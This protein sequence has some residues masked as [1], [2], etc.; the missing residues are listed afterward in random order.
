MEERNEINNRLLKEKIVNRCING[1]S[2]TKHITRED[3]PYISCDFGYIFTT[4]DETIEAIVKITVRDSEYYISVSEG[5]MKFVDIDD[6]T[7]NKT[8]SMMKEL[9][10][11]LRSTPPEEDRQKYRKDKSIDILKRTGIPYSTELPCL[12]DDEDVRVK[13]KEEVCKRAITSLVVAQVAYDIENDDYEESL[14]TFVPILEQY[15]VQD[16]LNAQEKKIIDGTYTQKDVDDIDM[17]YECYWALCWYL[18]LLND[19][20]LT[21]VS[22]ICDGE[23]AISFV[24][25]CANFE[26][27]YNKCEV[28]NVDELLDM[29]DLFY[30]LNW[31]I[32]E[33][34]VRGEANNLRVNSDVVMARRRGLEWII[35]DK[36][37]WNDIELNA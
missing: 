15:N 29:E 26:E 21:N 27:F 31:G 6:E 25:N 13:S 10:E 32:N 8:V 16:C 18:G 33:S 4:A 28:R 5:S 20:D 11:C 1:L 17:A 30:R 34:I 22:T 3:Y 19:S 7:F 23:R 36:T 37:D 14:K 35:S 9:H 24:V 12:Y 2:R